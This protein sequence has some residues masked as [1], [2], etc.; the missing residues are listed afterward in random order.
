MC[1]KEKSPL[2]GLSAGGSFRLKRNGEG[3][4]SLSF[5]LFDHGGDSA[6]FQAQKAMIQEF[7]LAAQSGQCHLVNGRLFVDVTALIA[8]ADYVSL[9]FETPVKRDEVPDC[10]VQA[11]DSQTQG[12]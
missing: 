1:E 7:L 2:G 12:R 9:N 5:T 3:E 11:A 10:A 4:F 6:R 8:R